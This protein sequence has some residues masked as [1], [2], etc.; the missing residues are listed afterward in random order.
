MPGSAIHVDFLG[1]GS[2]EAA[3]AAP[4]KLSA[5]VG[6]PAPEL[7]CIRADRVM[8]RAWRRGDDRASP[9]VADDPPARAGAKRSNFS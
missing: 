5:P 6:I 8:S 2:P 4:K 9:A 1:R 3:A 7:R